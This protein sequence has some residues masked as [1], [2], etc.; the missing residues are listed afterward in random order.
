M[1][2]LQSWLST[3][4]MAGKSLAY[5]GACSS[6][7]HVF[8]HGIVV[9][10]FFLFFCI[11]RLLL[12]VA[13]PIFDSLATT[14][15]TNRHCTQ[16]AGLTQPQHTPCLCSSGRCRKAQRAKHDVPPPCALP[17]PA[18]VFTPTFA[19][20][21]GGPIAPLCIKQPCCS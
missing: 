4:T 8:F 6:V 13:F 14:Y 21:S 5:L 2:N 16:L 17:P 9:R 19:I 10:L 11:W 3:M 7:P 18:L 20:L 1:Q 15:N 12:L